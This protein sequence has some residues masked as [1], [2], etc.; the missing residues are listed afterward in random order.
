MP[1]EF[2]GEIFDA[3]GVHVIRLGFLSALDGDYNLTVV[4]Q[5]TGVRRGFGLELKDYELLVSIDPT[6]S[7]REFGVEQ[8]AILLTLAREK[9]V[10]FV[11]EDDDFT[12]L[13]MVP[14]VRR[15]LYVAEM[16]AEGYRIRI[17]EVDADAIAGTTLSDPFFT[18][19]EYGARFIAAID[20]L[21]TVGDIV[22]EVE[23][24][25]LANPRDRDAI[26]IGE[27]QSGQSFRA[28][29]LAEAFAFIKALTDSGST[30]F[31]PSA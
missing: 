25:A 31:E 21:R 24:A 26:A 22:T 14:V 11:S 17:G 3:L 1:R 27:Q 13:D 18:V 5:P 10:T 2:D 8:Q 29:L 16:L 30:T 15:P 6:V 4:D 20:G 28:Y 9:A 7:N 12:A 19:S 23:A